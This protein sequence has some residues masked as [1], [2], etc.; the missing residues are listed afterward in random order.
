LERL[1]RRLA[2]ERRAREEAE[3]LL[4]HKSLELFEA[5]EQLKQLNLDLRY[6]VAE[7]EAHIRKSEYAANHCEVTGLAN[8]RAISKQLEA[9]ANEDW[10]LI[11]FDLDRFKQINDTLG[12]AAGDF[13]LQTVGDRLKMA[14]PDDAFIG[15]FGGDEFVIM[16]P[17]NSRGSRAENVAE[18]IH[19]QVSRPIK[20]IGSIAMFTFSIGICHR[21]PSHRNAEDIFLE[22][23]LALY[24]A[25]QSGRAR[26][27][28]F[29]SEMR[30]QADRRR[31][32]SEIVFEGLR[33]RQFIP[34]YMPR[35]DAVSGEVRCVEALARW[36]HPLLGSVEPAQFLDV[37]D[38]IGQVA[39]IDRQILENAASDWADWNAAGV[40]IPKFSVNVSSRRLMEPDL[41]ERVKDIGLPSGVV[42]FELLESVFL[43]D[44]DSEVTDRLD[45][46]RQLGVGIEIDDFGSGHASINGLL[47]VRPNALKIDR[48]LV[49]GALGDIARTELLASVV[50]IGKALGLTVVAE[51][52]ETKDH[53]RL[54]REL[55][56]DQLQGWAIA[57]AMPSYKLHQWLKSTRHFQPI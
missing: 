51:G 43:D 16:L 52:V 31:Q 13:V 35:I 37:A 1:E 45:A 21:H 3:S 23:D 49:T 18:T 17:N 47:A 33:Q 50:A 41:L 42:T 27:V 9:I 57:K 53:I 11:L 12:H 6:K 29:N 48:Q 4:E 20:Y 56:C 7:I 2:R 32:L 19:S 5:N 36:S 10:A 54:C 39:A 55:G 14:C 26:T 30:R 15:R 24:R 25:K 34:H 38:S 8:R 46:L 22:A 44:A 40:A 28:V